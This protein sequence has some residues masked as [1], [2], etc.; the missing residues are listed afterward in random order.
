[1]EVSYHGFRSIAWI[2]PAGETLKEESAMGWTMVR[3]SRESAMQMPSGRAA[4]DLVF[5]AAI[6]ANISLRNPRAVRFMRA[7]LTG[8]DFGT[9]SLAT[10]RQRVEGPDSGIVEVRA[11][12]PDPHAAPAL[13]IST[14]ALRPYLIPEALVQSDHPAIIA[15]ARQAV[16]SETNAWKAAVRIGRWVNRT[17]TKS[18]TLSIPSAL[19]VLQTRQGDCN[20]HTILFVALARAVGIPAEICAGIVYL[21]DSFFYHAWPRVWVG[22]WV[23]MDPTFGQDVADATHIEFV[24]GGLERQAEILRLVGRLQVRII[25][26]QP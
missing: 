15:A 17:V 24:R 4:P 12:K 8:A 22:Q 9:L 1:A 16:G 20:E 26:T 14:P 25:R 23:S 6:P 5:S 3:Q 21:N 10:D 7:E 19:D 13:P 11:E 18:P 2:T